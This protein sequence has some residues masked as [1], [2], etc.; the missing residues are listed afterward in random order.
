M[1]DLSEIYDIKPPFK[2]R[3]VP[4]G[5]AA[6]AEVVVAKN[7]TMLL[8][9]VPPIDGLPATI[10]DH[11]MLGIAKL[12]VGNHHGTITVLA[13]DFND[14]NHR[15]YEESHTCFESPQAM[16]T[17]FSHKGCEHL[18]FY[19]DEVIE[20][21]NMFILIKA[22]ANIIDNG[23]YLS[24]IHVNDKAFN[25]SGM[26]VKAG[27]GTTAIPLVAPSGIVRNTV[28]IVNNYI[29][30]NVHVIR[31]NM[32]APHYMQDMI[33]FNDFLLVD[34]NPITTE[35][36]QFCPACQSALVEVDG[37]YNC[38][39]S[40]CSPFLEAF[41]N[42]I[43]RQSGIAVNTLVDQ[44]KREEKFHYSCDSTI[45]EQARE[46]IPVDP[47]RT[48]Y[49]VLGLKGL[50]GI[51]ERFF[52]LYNDQLYCSKASAIDEM[53][54]KYITFANSEIKDNPRSV[55]Y[56]PSF[57]S[58][59]KVMILGTFDGLSEQTLELKL[60]SMG[61]GLTSVAQEADFCIAGDI[62]SGDEE[63]YDYVKE[64]SNILIIQTDGRI[65]NVFDLMKYF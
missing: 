40:D 34:E 17:S 38:T 28:K 54:Y 42:S 39:E 15:R 59:P 14:F 3:V 25:V 10:L 51:L 64:V 21:S 8:H 61:I 18:S 23:I 19:K 36:I 13:Q 11:S 12:P 1:T 20:C 4:A 63:F 7:M 6:I 24:E 52:G 2:L 27:E 58:R 45:E 55:V 50:K 62:K 60:S 29:D 35:A 9:A 47:I 65:Y 32:K 44:Y 26:R 16:V 53:F 5:I 49:D 31:K 57:N 43:S 33:L 37:E 46:E 30:G 48:Y 56:F 22:L 41:L